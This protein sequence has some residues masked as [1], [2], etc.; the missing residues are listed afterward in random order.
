QRLVES[1]ERRAAIARDE[2]RGVEPCRGVA[3]AL[4]D[5]QAHERLYAGQVNAAGVELVLVGQGYVAQRNCAGGGGGHG[6]SSRNF[7]SELRSAGRRPSYSRCD[8]VTAPLR[9]AD[10]TLR[11][12]S[13]QIALRLAKWHPR[14]GG[15]TS[16]TLMCPDAAA[17]LS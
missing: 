14:C 4:H 8:C 9:G 3:L 13:G 15:Q 6:A 17:A 10:C 7:V 11:P 1:A 12:A 16:A 5:E 2:A